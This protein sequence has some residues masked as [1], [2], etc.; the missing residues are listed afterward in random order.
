MICDIEEDL[1]RY[2]PHHLP[3]DATSHSYRYARNILDISSSYAIKSI[4]TKIERALN[5]PKTM[6][7]STDYWAAAKYLKEMGL[8]KTLIELYNY[9]E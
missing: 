8:P 3:M 6:P 9:L 2:R 4:K 7:R 1:A 5:D